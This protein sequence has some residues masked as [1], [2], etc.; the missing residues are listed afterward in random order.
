MTM[1]TKPFFSELM[2]LRFYR[3]FSG[4]KKLDY[5]IICIMKEVKVVNDIV[6]YRGGAKF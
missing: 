4:K 2:E 5:D 3:K 1:T 6:R